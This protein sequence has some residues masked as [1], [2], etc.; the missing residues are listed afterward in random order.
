MI[1]LYVCDSLANFGGLERVLIDRANWLVD[2]RDYE[3]CIVTVNQ[4][5]HPISFP[6]H[7]GVSYADLNILS[8]QHY[9]LPFWK[10]LFK[11]RQLQRLLCKRMANIITEKKPDVIVC[12]RFDYLRVID[13]T[14]GHIPFVYESHSAC[15][16]CRFEGDSLLRQLYVRYLLLAVNKAQMVVA[17]TKGDADEWLKLTSDVCVIPNV[18]NLNSS[19]TY[20]HCTS[21]SVIYVGRFCKQKDVASLL[22][23]WTLVHQ[24]HPD[25]SLHVY[26]GYGDEQEAFHKEVMRIDANIIIH[27]STLDII[28]KYKDSSML[29]LTSVYEPFG[30]VLPEAM[31]CGLPVVA[32]DCPYGPADIIT[33]GVDGFLI[34]QRSIE[35]FADKVCLLMEDQEL[36]VKM[37]K[38]GIESSKRYDASNIMPQWIDFFKQFKEK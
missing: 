16:A 26:G 4:G 3:V 21:K 37:G 14:R 12:T 5:C 38:A 6:L 13:K 33:D 17:L 11:K 2:Q 29:L 1:I 34:R 15:L 35:M 19:N 24:R 20:S 8:Y 10:R 32:F 36:R 7:S 25:W 31:S 30:L 27:E 22:R 23:I 18:V 28:E 9:R